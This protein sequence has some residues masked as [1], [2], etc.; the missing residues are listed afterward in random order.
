MGKIVMVKEPISVTF[1][2]AIGDRV[3]IRVKSTTHNTQLKAAIIGRKA[4]YH[5]EISESAV[6]ISEVDQGP[7]IYYSF[8]TENYK[9]VTQENPTH[10]IEIIRRLG[11]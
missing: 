10:T 7:T 4:V 2:Y 6:D 9:V 11:E 1:D 5:K 3:E 8:V